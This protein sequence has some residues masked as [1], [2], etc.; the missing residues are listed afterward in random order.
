MGIA[1][2]ATNVIC[3]RVSPS[4]KSKLVLMMKRFYRS[5][6]T[7][8]IGDGGNDVPMIMEAHIGVGI[9][10]EEGIGAVKNS[11]YVIEEFQF[12]RSLLFY[13]GRTNYI[14]N[15]EWVMYIFNQNFCL[16]LLQFIYG[17][18]C[19]FIG[20]TIIDEDDW[21]IFFYNLL[22]ILPLY[23]KALLD[24]DIKPSDGLIFDRMLPFLYAENRNNPLFTFPKFCLNLLRN[25]LYY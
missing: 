13:H 9:Y 17:F 12:L 18:Y 1:K 19:N 7:L 5:A 24:H 16:A 14:R 2:D 3:C 4:Q 25:S 20:Q 15:A 10:G 6:V 22:F 23:S 8:D 11:D 21:L